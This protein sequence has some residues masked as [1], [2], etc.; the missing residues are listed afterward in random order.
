M[1]P[2]KKDKLKFFWKQNGYLY[3]TDPDI[4]MAKLIAYFEDDVPDSLLTCSGTVE[5]PLNPLDAEF[6]CPGYL[7]GAV[8][9]MTNSHL[10]Q[11]YKQSVADISEDN[12]DN[13]K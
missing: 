13:S 3:I 10:L 8:L 11:T 9:E 2:N 6:K 7:E 4:D 5:C 1:Y 12:F